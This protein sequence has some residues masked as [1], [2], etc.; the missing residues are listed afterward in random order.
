MRV[1]GEDFAS[2]EG[3]GNDPAR[4]VRAFLRSFPKLRQ[5][6]VQH[7][8]RPCRI[9]APPKSHHFDWRGV[10]R[11]AVAFDDLFIYEAHVR[12]L[13]TEG[14]FAS[15]LGVIP[16]LNWLGVTAVQVMPVFEFSE[17]ECGACGGNFALLGCDAQ[18]QRRGNMWGYS[19]MS[20]FSPMNRYAREACGGAAELK[21][22]VRA[23]HEVGI[24]CFLDV[25]YNHSANASCALHFLK[26]QADYYMGKQGSNDA[27]THCNVS[28]CGNT[29]SPNSPLMMDLL[30]D[31]LRWFVTEYR[32]DGFRI[33]AAGIFCRD[34]SSKPMRDPPVIARICADPVLRDTK[35]IVEGW[36]AGDQVGLPNM[37]LGS[38][39]GFPRGGR[40][41]EW[42][43][44][45][46]D[47]VR[48]FV[49]GESGSARAFCKALRGSAYLFGDGKNMKSCRPLGAGHG[50][51]FV[52]CHDGFCMLDVVSFE[53]RVNRDGYDEISFNCGTEGRTDDAGVKATRAQQVR[54]FFFVLAISRGVP[55]ICQ[56][57]EL[58]FSKEGNNNTWNSPT[59]YAGKLP[60]E[61]RACSNLEDIVQFVKRMFDLRASLK[62]LKGSD[63]FRQLVWLNILGKPREPTTISERRALG[64]NVKTGNN[65]KCSTVDC[66]V[67]FQTQPDDN[68]KSLYVGINMSLQDITAY[69]PC[70]NHGMGWVKVIGTHNSD[71]PP[72]PSQENRLSS[73]HQVTICK[74]SSVLYREEHL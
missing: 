2:A 46:R 71:W 10:C 50:I 35:F 1:E 3:V 55:M 27:F 20:W 73:F 21:T 32:I 52:A 38:E 29:L 22:S 34:Q 30:M 72:I 42:N 45:W 44:E 23:L 49:K 54:N 41:C 6:G 58:G 74:Q 7:P 8:F 65:L 14:T 53:E 25:V 56:G 60:V 67:A 31:S 70:S 13:T 11:P 9:I 59:L 26:V 64:I 40:F 61:P 63:F 57:D 69:L 48:R 33:D 66:F 24:E 15:A 17:M 12:A 62:Q 43:V 19:P 4:N 39:H 36:D 18:Q 28:G 37:L 5:L 47:A 16:Y 51:N 68:G